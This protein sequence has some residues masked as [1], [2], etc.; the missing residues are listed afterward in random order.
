MEQLKCHLNPEHVQFEAQMCSQ[1]LSYLHATWG[2]FNTCACCFAQGTHMPLWDNG[3][4][5]VRVLDYRESWASGIQ[6]TAKAATKGGHGK[7]VW[8]RERMCNIP[9]QDLASVFCFLEIKLHLSF[10]VPSVLFSWSLYISLPT[11][12]L[13]SPS[14]SLPVFLTRQ[15]CGVMHSEW[16]SRAEASDSPLRERPTGGQTGREQHRGEWGSEWKERVREGWWGT[17]ATEWDERTD[18]WEKM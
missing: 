9:P 15:I 10:F 13:L 1:L 3:S 12:L 8:E 2:I 17:G 6:T 16:I 14:L 5:V 18:R 4:N 7:L 11:D